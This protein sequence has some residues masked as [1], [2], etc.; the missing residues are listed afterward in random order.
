MELVANCYG[1]DN[2]VCGVLSIEGLDIFE[3]PL[4]AEVVQSTFFLV[5]CKKCFS[6]LRKSKKKALTALL[7][8]G[9]SA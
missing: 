3:K 7:S 4:L 1:V 8:R 5:L 9:M 2:N 6:L